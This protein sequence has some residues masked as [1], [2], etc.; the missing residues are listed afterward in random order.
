MGFEQAR[1]ILAGVAMV[2]ITAGPSFADQ[3]PK[4]AAPAK[5]TQ[6]HVMVAVNHVSQ[7]PGPVDPAAAKL[8]RRLRQDFKYKSVRVIQSEKMALALNQ[9]GT[10][11]LPTGRV[12]KVKPRKLGQ[13]GLLMSVEIEG[14]LRTS[15]RVPNHHQVVIGAQNYQDGKLVV[16]LEPEYEYP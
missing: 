4:P 10:M 9:T 6:V 12:L 2:A 15:L 11:T 16:T 7:H 8:E 1:S 13:R 5:P 3:A 14:T